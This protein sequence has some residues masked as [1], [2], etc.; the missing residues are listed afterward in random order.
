MAL[1]NGGFGAALQARRVSI[2]QQD[3]IRQNRDTLYGSGVFDL[4][5]GPVTVTL[6]D[7]GQTFR[8]DADH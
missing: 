4:N 2:D 8:L 1:K 6:P 5:A 3:V 7:R